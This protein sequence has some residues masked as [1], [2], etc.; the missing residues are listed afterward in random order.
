MGQMG[1]S[2]GHAG[3]GAVWLGR[4]GHRRAGDLVWA[5]NGPREGELGHGSGDEEEVGCRLQ[6]GHELGKGKREKIKGKGFSF[7]E[8]DSKTRGIGEEKRKKD[9]SS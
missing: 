6:L 1:R 3:A 7:Y 5:C 8:F 4:A 9:P 2:L